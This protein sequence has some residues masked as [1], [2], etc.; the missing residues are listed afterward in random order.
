MRKPAGLS[1]RVKKSTHGESKI[2]DIA[3][4]DNTEKNL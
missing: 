4:D 1:K 3:S 2:S